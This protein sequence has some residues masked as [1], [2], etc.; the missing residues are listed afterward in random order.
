MGLQDE[1]CRCFHISFLWS[2]EEDT[3]SGLKELTAQRDMD[4]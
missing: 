3:S 4:T 2:A 1:F